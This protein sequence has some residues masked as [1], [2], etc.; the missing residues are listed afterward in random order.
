MWHRVLTKTFYK[1]VIIFEFFFKCLKPKEIIHLGIPKCST[2]ESQLPGS[3]KVDKVDPV[4]WGLSLSCFCYPAHLV[5]AELTLGHSQRSMGN[6]LLSAGTGK[7]C[8]CVCVNFF[9]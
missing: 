9:H 4:W 7:G 8:V 3:L 6:D 1:P 5:S 2:H